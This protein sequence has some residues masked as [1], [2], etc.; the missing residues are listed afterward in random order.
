MPADSA[1]ARAV[2]YQLYEAGEDAIISNSFAHFAAVLESVPGAMRLAY[3]AEINLGINGSPFDQAR[4]RRG[5]QVLQDDLNEKEIHPGST[6]YCQG[7]GWLALGEHDTAVETY[8]LALAQ[9]DHPRV[10]GVAAQ[11]CKNMGSA[12]GALGE[13]DAA[14]ASYQQALEFDPD[15]AEAHLALGVWHCHH[16]ND[17]RRALEHF[18]RVAVRDGS[19]LA[20]M[21]IVEVWR[22]DALF[23][24]GD[25]KAAFRDIRSLLREADRV[26]WIWPSCARKV[27][28]YGRGSVESAREAVAFWRA[29]V[30]DHPDHDVAERER[31]LCLCYLRMGEAATGTDFAEFRLAAM[32]LIRRGDREAAL[33][34]DRVGHWAQKDGDWVQAESA[35]RE[36][37]QLE[38]ERYGYCL[39]TALNFLKR[40]GEALPILL[41]QAEAHQPDAMSWFQVAV[42]SE[43]V[44]DIGRSISA[45]QRA[46]ALDPDYALAWFNLG[47]VFW[48]SQ[49]VARAAV[50][51]REAVARFPDHPLA[52]K[53]RLVVPQLFAADDPKAE[54]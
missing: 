15:L 41:C 48:N 40:H 46:L 14:R 54:H 19:Q 7:N 29:Y 36:A 9:L 21:R 10:R 5:I 3:M 22:A 42:A 35:Y 47:G 51:W 45:Y 53:L 38:P 13:P 2:L 8:R 39:G 11:C 30:R 31:L 23:K 50:T 37:W 25:A 18:D 1:R 32:R 44:R 16:G 49:D 43:G 52:E 33:L 17:P 27:A 34:W 4:V 12:L 6:L 26:D 24:I 28:T 20:V